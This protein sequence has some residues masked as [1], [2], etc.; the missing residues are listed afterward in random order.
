M[1]KG[2]LSDLYFVIAALKSPTSSP[3]PHVNK[4]LHTSTSRYASA[5]MFGISFGIHCS[6]IL[7]IDVCAICQTGPK[8]DRQFAVFCR[9]QPL[10]CILLYKGC[11]DHPVC[12]A[13]SHG[14][15]RWHG[16]AWYGMVWCGVVWCGMVWY[17]MV[18]YGMLLLLL[19][20]APSTCRREKLP[21]T[22]SLGRAQ[23]SSRPASRWP[24]VCRRR[25]RG[26][27][28]GGRRGVGGGGGRVWRRVGS[29]EDVTLGPSPV[30]RGES[31]SS[32]AKR[33]WRGRRVGW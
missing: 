26:G 19:L 4:A 33:L 27:G 2:E 29:P 31:H 12:T 23:G 32:C 13:S 3:Q 1:Q 7:G 5:A 16:L 25:P 24:G 21:D 8:L 10:A 11:R 20:R 17:G 18:W 15:V 9:P 28:G 14:M 22:L 30:S 6:V